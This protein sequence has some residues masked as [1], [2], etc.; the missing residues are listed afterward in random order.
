MRV[1]L[2]PV[3]LTVSMMAPAA[4]GNTAP[5]TP[6]SVQT[7]VLQL[8]AHSQSLQQLLG[9]P[10]DQQTLSQIDEL[11]YQLECDLLQLGTPAAAV[12]EPLE[13]L[14]QAVENRDSNEVARCGG[15]YLAAVGA[16][17]S[18]RE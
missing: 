17:L 10:L 1:Y 8:S 14:H 11:S 7:S 9:K 2:I 16:W 5:A 4:L 3:S 6:S 13:S 12:A 15:A 18:G